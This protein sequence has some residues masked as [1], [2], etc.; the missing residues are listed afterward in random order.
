[1]MQCP[2]VVTLGRRSSSQF[3]AI[4]VWG[5][6]NDNKLKVYISHL[7][8]VVL[9]SLRHREPFTKNEGNVIKAAFGRAKC[10]RRN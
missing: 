2:I 3:D 10:G 6:E 5:K 4:R 7:L 8:I 1:M 9:S